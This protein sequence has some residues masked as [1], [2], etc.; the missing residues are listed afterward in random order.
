MALHINSNKLSASISAQGGVMLGLW[1]RQE[2][3]S[4]TALLRSAAH[5]QVGPGDS[6]GFPMV[7]F[8]NRLGGNSFTFEGRIH[9]LAANSAHDP[10]YLHGDG[11]LAFWNVVE[12]SENALTL[13]YRHHSDGINPYDYTARQV[14]RVD[15]HGFSLH[16]SVVNEGADALPFGLGWHPYFP[17]RPDS[18]LEF[19]AKS[20]HE[21]AEGS[22]L[23]NELELSDP[24]DFRKPRQ[25]P[26]RWINNG[27]SGLEG[28][29]RILWPEAGLALEMSYDPIFAHAF[30][31]LPYAANSAT[32]MPDFFCLEPMTHNANGQHRPDLGGLRILA[33]GE[34]LAGT[35]HLTVDTLPKSFR[36]ERSR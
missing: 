4:Q 25:L 9:H 28:S 27:F 22:L 26:D 35:I 8:G 13:S 11:W 17:L 7:P 31:Y 5:D 24:L 10:L 1:W 33:P 34:T 18:L 20:F 2:N 36:S 6:A 21:E 23:G 19:Q 32:A 12:R 3:G 15:E 16:L 14:F 30:L 29:T